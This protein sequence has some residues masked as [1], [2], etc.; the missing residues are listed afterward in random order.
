M[1][2]ARRIWA[3]TLGAALALTGGPVAA[4]TCANPNLGQIYAQAQKAE[5]PYVVVRGRAS[6]GDQVER[7]RRGGKTE[8]FGTI[9]I[10][11][12]S[13]SQ[14]GF[15]T[16]F[17]APVT[18][19]LDCVLD[20]WCAA[21]PK[22]GRAVYFLKKTGDAAYQLEVSPCGFW[23][24]PDPGPEELDLLLRCHRTDECTP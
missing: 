3:L 15:S 11:G 18:V 17:D 13:L 10:K 9:R 20:T 5:A 2:V 7:P 1:T 24:A 21:P 23:V 8:T 16:R 12:R 19:R 14:S 4:L 22:G 6:G